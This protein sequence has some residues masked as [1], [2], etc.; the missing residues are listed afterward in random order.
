MN[1]LSILLNKRTL[2]GDNYSKLKR[3]INIVLN[4]DKITWVLSDHEPEALIPQSTPQDIEYHKKWHDANEI[5]KCYIL[6]SMNSILQKQHEGMELNGAEID[7]KTQ[8]SMIVH[9]L[10]L[11]FSQFILDYELHTRDYTLNGLMND[12]QNVEEVLDLKKKLEAHAISTSKPKPK[13]KK[14]I[15]GNKKISKGSVGAKKKPMK[16]KTAS[17]DNTKGK[18]FHLWCERTLEAKLQGLP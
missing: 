2:N 7:A 3:N 5:A 16:K 12:L 10:N 9:S 6:A 1:P 14:K 8:I 15:V 17:K 18:C 4:Y 13:G 11:S